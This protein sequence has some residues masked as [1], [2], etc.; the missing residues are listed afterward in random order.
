MLIDTPPMP[1]ISPS[2]EIE[3]PRKDDFGAFS[4]P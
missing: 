2:T 4:A 1:S 3:T